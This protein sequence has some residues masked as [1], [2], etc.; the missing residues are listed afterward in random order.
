MI[1]YSLFSW[2][3]D[4]LLVNGKINNGFYRNS[5]AINPEALDFAKGLIILFHTFRYVK[6]SDG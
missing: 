3:L 5:F 2:P 6:K 4:N 1:S